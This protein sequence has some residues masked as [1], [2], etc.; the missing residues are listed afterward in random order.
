[1][2]IILDAEIV[3]VPPDGYW[4]LKSGSWIYTGETFRSS[5]MTFLDSAQFTLLKTGS[6]TGAAYAYLYQYTGSA[7]ST[8]R[9]IGVPLATSDAFDVSTLTTS[10]VLRTITFSGINRYIIQANVY[11]VIVIKYLNGTA[12]N[13]ISVGYSTTTSTTGNESRSLDGTTWTYS[14]AN[15]IFK[16]YGET[17]PARRYWVPGGNGLFWSGIMGTGAGTDGNNWS[18]TSGGV[19]GATTPSYG[20]T[21][22]FDANSGIGPITFQD[23]RVAN[24][25]F[26]GFNGTI[27]L[28]NSGNAINIYSSY[29]KLNP[30]M[31]INSVYPASPGT[32]CFRSSCVFYTMGLTINGSVMAYGTDL[33]LYGDLNI[34]GVLL[35]QHGL[36]EANDYNVTMACYYAYVPTVAYTCVTNMG[37]ETWTITGY[38]GQFYDKAWKV[39]GTNLTL[40]SETSKLVFNNSSSNPKSLGNG[41]VGFVFNQVKFTGT[42]TGDFNI[43]KS[44]SF[45]ILTVDTPPHSVH[46]ERVTTQY[47]G[48]LNINGLGASKIILDSTVSGNTWI[49]NISAGT[50]TCN[51][52][53][54]RDCLA[55]GGAT[56]NAVDSIDVGN[57][58]GWNFSVTPG[59]TNTDNISI[60][61]SVSVAI[62]LIPPDSLVSYYKLDGDSSDSMWTNNGVDYNVTYSNSYGKIKQ[63][64]NGNGTNTH[65]DINGVTNTFIG[66][67]TEWSTKKILG[68]D[69]TKNFTISIWFYCTNTCSG[70][71][72]SAVNTLD[73]V[74]SGWRALELCLEPDAALSYAFRLKRSASNFFSISTGNF[75]AN[76]WHQIVCTSKANTQYLYLDG[77]LITSIYFDMQT[78]IFGSGLPGFVAT[79][80][81]D[82]ACPTLRYAGLTP[83]NYE[84]EVGFWSR[85]LTDDEVKTLNNNGNGIQFPFTSFDPDISVTDTVSISEYVSVDRYPATQPLSINIIDIA[86]TVETSNANTSYDIDVSVFDT[87]NISESSNYSIVDP[88]RFIDVYDSVSIKEDIR[89]NLNEVENMRISENLTIGISQSESVSDVENLTISE[90]YTVQIPSIDKSISVSENINIAN[91]AYMDVEPVPFFIDIIDIAYTIETSDSEIVYGVGVSDT[92]N[93]SES[94]TFSIV[95]PL[96]INVFDLVNTREDIRFNLTKVDQLNI[97][98]NLTIGFSEPGSVS[99]VE[100]LTVS[101]SYSVGLSQS[102]SVDVSDTMSISGVFVLDPLLDEKDYLNIE[103]SVSVEMV[104]I[105]NISVVDNLEIE[106]NVGFQDI[107]YVSI[108]ENISIDAPYTVESF[109]FSPSPGG[110][111]PK[112]TMQGMNPVA[113]NGISM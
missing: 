68:L 10:P 27:L 3:K 19:A 81:I 76:S 73:W 39:Q 56:F 99:K 88:F 62:P 100:N 2:A 22:Y 18:Y 14:S 66:T 51:Y 52:V 91:N 72:F 96:Y 86:Y 75:G 33:T 36:F 74:T 40:N 21:A 50:T 23:T 46:F 89:F 32:I 106:Q 16:V 42:G 64:V 45:N 59:M 43:L 15:L 92:L 60:S 55:T 80:L 113:R 110:S 34:T 95:D 78:K 107:R 90:N 61:E 85:A 53:S 57:N 79:S 97:S 105:T 112:A 93:I 111:R 67:A 41:N 17:M 20:D 8:A 102:L 101:E 103:E 38:D 4:V 24:I 94:V 28:H 108:I 37:S 49:L 5:T 65:I 1:M 12:S 47:V 70:K 54:I 84:D 29:L 83:T 35:H 7:G 104:G 11:Y 44:N 69:P 82:S 87:L 13:N 30:G 26:T 6:P 25:D 77:N 48:I 71:L 31:T 98:E 109:L 9:P 63:G 58:T